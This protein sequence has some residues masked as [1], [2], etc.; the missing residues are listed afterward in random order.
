MMHMKTGGALRSINHGMSDDVSETV[1][2]FMKGHYKK[3]MEK[4]FIEM[5]NKVLKLQSRRMKTCRIRSNQ[6]PRISYV[7]ELRMMIWHQEHQ[8]ATSKLI[9]NRSVAQ[10]R[11]TVIPLI[12]FWQKLVAATELGID[13]S[14]ACTGL[15]ELNLSASWAFEYYYKWII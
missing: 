2:K 4:V 13:P 8:L 9:L 5:M 7:A 10:L 11:P 1:E 14:M 6:I 3:C 12:L 15:V